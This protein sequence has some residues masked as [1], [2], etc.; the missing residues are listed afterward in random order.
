M[1]ECELFCPKFREKTENGKM[2]KSFD[3][4]TREEINTEES[5]AKQ[6]NV[7]L[8]RAILAS[9]FALSNSFPIIITV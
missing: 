4:K 8:K 9:E 3:N 1:K 2:A 5:L 7:G 6:N